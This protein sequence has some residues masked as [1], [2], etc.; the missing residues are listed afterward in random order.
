M[1]HIYSN[2]AQIKQRLL[3]TRLKDIIL[4]NRGIDKV[5]AECTVSEVFELNTML[6]LASFD[7]I[8]RIA[9]EI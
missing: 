5:M 1:K 4:N 9:R 2:K 8:K 3:N 6:D 7:Y